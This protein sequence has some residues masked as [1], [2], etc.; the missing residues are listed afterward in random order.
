MKITIRVLGLVACLGVPSAVLAQASKGMDGGGGSSG[1]AS[2]LQDMTNI[3]KRASC[4]SDATDR[5]F[6]MVAECPDDA[7]ELAACSLAAQAIAD[8]KKMDC[9]RDFPVD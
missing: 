4:K 2:F 7:L 3:S 1:S 5:L 9:D 8:A 6:D